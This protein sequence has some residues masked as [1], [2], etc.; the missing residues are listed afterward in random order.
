MNSLVVKNLYLQYNFG[1]LALQNINFEISQ[2][3]ILTILAPNEGG[4]TSLIKSLAGLVKVLRGDINLNGKNITELSAKDRNVSVMYENGC[5]FNNKSVFFNL[6]Y[7][8]KIRKTD[9][10]L[11][12]KKI[13]ELLE[14]FDLK[15]VRDIKVRKLSKMEKFKVALARVFIRESDIYLIDDPLFIYKDSERVQIFEYFLPYLKKL[16]EKAP[17]VY[18]T[19]SIEETKILKENVIILNYGVQLQAGSLDS[20]V[21]RPNNVLSYKLFHQNVITE[22]TRII[23]GAKGIYLTISGREVVLDIEKLINPIYV[24]TEILACYLLDGNEVD[25]SSLYLF[26]KNSEK[27]VFFN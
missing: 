27:L 5:L 2:G 20:I 12:N 23:Q 9:L 18:A 25:L 15:N 3:N 11:A 6:M 16:S 7:P 17:L 1:T 24:D 26:D 19:S 13:T 8:L 21:A 4:K 10:D 22:E 14:E